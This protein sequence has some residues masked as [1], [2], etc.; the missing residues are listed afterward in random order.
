MRSCHTRNCLG[1]AKYVKSDSRLVITRQHIVTG[2]S[3]TENCSFHPSGGGNLLLHTQ[4]GEVC[5]RDAEEKVV[6]TATSLTR[7][8]GCKT[9]SMTW[10]ARHQMEFTCALSCSSFFTVVVLPYCCLPLL[11]S[12][13]I[14]CCAHLMF[15]PTVLVH[16]CKLL[17]P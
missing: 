16:C 1:G 10:C 3:D 14:R 12:V 6:T 5:L 17:A 13:G 4:W 9:S 8:E 15:G 11:S 2:D 7:C